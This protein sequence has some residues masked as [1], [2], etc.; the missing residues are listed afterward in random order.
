MIAGIF[1]DQ[2]HIVYIYLC[3]LLLFHSLANKCIQIKD[4][5]FG[6]HPSIKNR[7]VTIWKSSSVLPQ[8]RSKRKHENAIEMRQKQL[9]QAKNAYIYIYATACQPANQQ[10]ASSLGE[11]KQEIKKKTMT[12]ALVSLRS[13]EH[14]TAHN[15]CR[16]G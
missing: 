11:L 2:V 6:A 13:L 5:S 7:L 10:V 1:L 3:E 12:F 9:Q 8:A 14:K 4:T 16:K 15:T